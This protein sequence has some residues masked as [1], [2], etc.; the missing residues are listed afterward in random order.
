MSRSPSLSLSLM[1]FFP[2]YTI[3]TTVHGQFLES[4]AALPSTEWLS[5]F[6]EPRKAS[7]T[8][9]ESATARACSAHVRTHRRVIK[10]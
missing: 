1:Q 6:G 4:K 3:C 8:A 10:R 9:R 7:L 5:E 2:L